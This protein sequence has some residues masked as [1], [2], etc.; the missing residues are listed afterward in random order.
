MFWPTRVEIA[1]D[2]PIAGMMTTCSDVRADAVGGERQGAEAGDQE[3]HH[4]QPERAC[5]HLDRGGEAEEEGTLHVGEVGDE[6]AA[7]DMDAVQAE[8]QHDDAD[9]R[10]DRPG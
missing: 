1:I 3:G 2:R 5:R 10:G 6:V 9:D 7:P 8:P 4:H